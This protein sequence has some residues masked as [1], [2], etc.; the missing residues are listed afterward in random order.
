[1]LRTRSGAGENCLSK[2]SSKLQI[3]LSRSAKGLRPAVVF[4]RLTHSASH[5]TMIWT[6]PG[7]PNRVFAQHIPNWPPRSWQCLNHL[8][9]SKSKILFQSQ[10]LSQLLIHF[11]VSAASFRRFFLK[12]VPGTCFPKWSFPISHRLEA[13]D[14]SG[15]SGEEAEA[16]QVVGLPPGGRRNT[17]DVK[18]TKLGR[19][20]G[21][22]YIILYHV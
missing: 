6:P 13:Q 20:Q 7:H 12:F 11:S 14:G 5:Q 3:Q 18:G 4:G 2:R 17:M 8:E 21:N 1:M 22:I 9:P 16:C 15:A 19:C 10:L